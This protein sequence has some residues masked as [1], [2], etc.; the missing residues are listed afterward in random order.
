MKHE[1]KGKINSEFVGLKSNKYSLI[2]VGNEENQKGKEINKKAVKNIIHKEY[3]DILFNKHIIRDKMK[4]IQCKLH[5]I[6]TYK[7]C[8][9]SLSSFNDKRYILDNGINSLACFD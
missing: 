3:I 6:R 2:D 1:V 8:K 9:I 4:R 7:V 5:T